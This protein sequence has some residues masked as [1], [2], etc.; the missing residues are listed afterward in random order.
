MR[1]RAVHALYFPHD[2]FGPIRA[3]QVRRVDEHGRNAV[4]GVGLLLVDDPGLV[5]WNVGHAGV[6]DHCPREIRQREIR[7]PDAAG[8]SVVDHKGLLVEKWNTVSVK[9]SPD[10]CLPAGPVRGLV[11]SETILQAVGADLQFWLT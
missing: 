11:R 5:I 8:A 3:A 2:P 10:L 6:F 1:G 7:V 9:Q 4:G